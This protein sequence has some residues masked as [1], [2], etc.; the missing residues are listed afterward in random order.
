MLKLFSISAVFAV[1][2]SASSAGPNI[3]DECRQLTYGPCVDIPEVGMTG[4]VA[5]VAA[6]AA[7]GAMV[8]ERRRRRSD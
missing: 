6:V 2:A 3:V 5:A 4:A 1:A 8:W 7:V